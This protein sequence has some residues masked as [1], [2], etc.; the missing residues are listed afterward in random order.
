MATGRAVAM[1]EPR[2][3]EKRYSDPN[4]SPISQF[5][6]VTSVPASALEALRDD[7][8]LCARTL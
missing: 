1:T 2:F 3:I 4:F 8:V 6:S 7:E 5:L